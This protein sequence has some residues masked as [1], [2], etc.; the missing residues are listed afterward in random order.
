MSVDPPGLMDD[1]LRSERL[2]GRRKNGSYNLVDAA[3]SWLD[4]LAGDRLARPHATRDRRSCPGHA[5]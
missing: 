1:L 2:L 5:P 4:G 3:G